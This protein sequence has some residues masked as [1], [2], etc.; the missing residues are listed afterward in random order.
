MAFL[1]SRMEYEVEEQIH[2][3]VLEL[4]APIRDPM[5]TLERT[6]LMV[7]IAKLLKQAW[8]KHAIEA[9]YLVKNGK[10]QLTVRG[11]EVFLHVREEGAT[12][13]FGYQ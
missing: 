3:C 6:E 7:A 4:M 1:D 5:S 10:E 11:K 8:R 12:L 13:S 9:T 2:R